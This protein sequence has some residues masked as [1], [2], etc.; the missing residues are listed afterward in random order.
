MGNMTWIE[1]LLWA[2]TIIGGT[3]FILRTIMMVVGVGFHH[4]DVDSSFAGDFHGD[5]DSSF[6]GDFHGDI[7]SDIHADIH[8]VHDVHDI[9]ADHHVDH[10][11]TEGDSDISFRLLS[12]QGLTAFFMMFGLVG[13]ALLKAKVNLFLILAGGGLAGYFT[14]H[15]LSLIFSQAMRLQSDGTLNIQNAVGQTGSVYLTIPAQGTGQ[16]QVTVQGA[17]RIIDARSKGEQV[18]KTGE[19]IRV[20]GVLGSSTL[21]VERIEDR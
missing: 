4:G 15:L 19:K 6:H 21:E 18:I 20:T 11:D 9:D 1:L 10:G 14:V 17:R 8:D 16:V 12:L 13:L 3:L 7:G 5:V 2:S